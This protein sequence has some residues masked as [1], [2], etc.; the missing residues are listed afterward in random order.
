MAGLFLSSGIGASL[1]KL[2]AARTRQAALE[3]CPSGARWR[4]RN[5]GNTGR[6]TPTRT[7]RSADGIYCQGYQLT[8][9]PGGRKGQAHGSAWRQPDGAW[10]V[11]N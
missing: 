6:I 4:N 8:V 5:T 3:T 11:S 1:E 2:Y 9:T 7:C 10:R